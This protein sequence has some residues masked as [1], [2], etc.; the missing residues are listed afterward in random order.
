[1]A[2]I[3]ISDGEGFT[4]LEHQDAE[5]AVHKA[6]VKLL[7][8]I[9]ALS[10]AAYKPGP[11]FSVVVPQEGDPDFVDEDEFVFRLDPNDY[12]ETTDEWET[13][14]QAQREREV[15]QAQHA[16]DRVMNDI[17]ARAAGIKGY[18]SFSLT[19]SDYPHAGLVMRASD[20]RLVLY[21]LA[22]LAA[23]KGFQNTLYPIKAS[24]GSKAASLPYK[25]D[26][27]V[28]AFEALGRSAGTPPF[29]IPRAEDAPSPG[30]N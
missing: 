29:F 19:E 7:A 1:M 11:F 6:Y 22:M 24:G 13:K 8:N 3:F 2:N 5:G 26:G 28:K 4:P 30:L 17:A 23:E 21:A 25:M 20:A 10:L 18:G 12:P 14:T 15:A 16:I 27:M 9:E